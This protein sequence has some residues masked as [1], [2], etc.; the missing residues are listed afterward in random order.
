M[1]STK[2]GRQPV[3][4]AIYRRGFNIRSAADKIGVKYAHLH[5]VAIGNVVPSDEVRER[6]PK[7]L[8]AE[9]SDLFTADALAARHNGTRGPKPG[10]KKALLS[11]GGAK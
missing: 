10:W 7:L 8:D 5:G 6:L 1:S 9:L 4:A 2:Y 11:E 3:Y